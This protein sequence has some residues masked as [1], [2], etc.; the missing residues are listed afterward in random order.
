MIKLW[1]E[2]VA[3]KS[4]LVFE[5][6]ASDG[7]K[8]T[9]RSNT[10]QPRFY[11][12]S[13][14]MLYDDERIV[15]TEPATQ[16]HILTGES[17]VRVFTDVTSSVGSLRRSTYR[18]EGQPSLASQADILFPEVALIE[19]GIQ[20]GVEIDDNLLNMDSLPF[21][22]FKPCDPPDTDE[23]QYVTN[24]LDIE[25]QH[26]PNVLPDIK[27]EKDVIYQI[28]IFQ[29]GVLKYFWLDNGYPI[30]TFEQVKEFCIKNELPI[31]EQYDPDNVVVCKAEQDLLIAFLE[32]FESLDPDVLTGWNVTFD[33]DY[34][35]GRCKRYRLGT[36]WWNCIRKLN[37]HDSMEAYKRLYRAPSN[38]FK[39]V[40]VHE[41]ITDSVV[42]DEHDVH[43][44]R[45]G[46]NAL[47]F[48]YNGFDVVW[49]EALDIKKS[50]IEHDWGVKE[51][52][53]FPDMTPTNWRMPVVDIVSLREARDDFILPSKMEWEDTKD[54]GEKK[55]GAIV[56]D[57]VPG[58]TYGVAILDFSMYYPIII[59]AHNLSR[60]IP[61]GKLTP[62]G[63]IPRVCERLI[64]HRL[65]AKAERK[66]CIKECGPDSVE[67]KKAKRLDDVSKFMLNSVFGVT[68]NPSFR[69]YD[70][71]VFEAITGYGREGLIDIK[72]MAEDRGFEVIYGD[73]DSLFI[74]FDN[75][76]Q[77]EEFAEEINNKLNAM[78]KEKYGLTVNFDIKVE[79]WLSPVV[80]SKKR[81]SKDDDEAG[82]KK[83]FYRVVIEDGINLEELGQ[84]YV[85]IM[86]HAMVRRDSSPLCKFVQKKVFEDIAF[87][88]VD[89]IIPFLRE[90]WEK[91][92]NGEFELDSIA[93]RMTIQKRFEDYKSPTIAVRGAQF[94]NEHMNPSAPIQVGD[95][96]RYVYVKSVDGRRATDVVA[97][98]TVKDVEGR[99]EVDYEVMFEKQIIAKT[100]DVLE[101]VD[102][103]WEQIMGQT[104]LLDLF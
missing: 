15:G 66:R 82:K 12:P 25:C 14:A 35:M 86:G 4:I 31:L 16:K 7:T 28:G 34:I 84:D 36:R 26:P 79:K 58:A 75:Y 77:A 63:I 98:N 49:L 76:Q 53:G 29:S 71:R 10:L 87:G 102:I 61:S 1:K 37:I 27:R 70:K 92:M 13:K 94:L 85:S 50:I 83:Y 47:C 72:K 24:Y 3:K 52:A 6:K 95:T 21:E 78:Y 80:F 103:N 96:V 54:M 69:L 33:T 91:Y 45:E 40:V 68:G 100:E 90:C 32:Y 88:R 62:K 11:L 48:T 5:L 64:K 23:C 67:A 97:Y 104:S 30:P 41:G 99:I 8:R 89:E 22:E 46:K 55:K 93:A 56:F 39:D 9:V 38:R 74:K 18:V 51:L 20:N 73:T 43:W 81:N 42:E 19:S 65:A 60:E 17:M 44:W 57:P 2:D 59:I 101:D